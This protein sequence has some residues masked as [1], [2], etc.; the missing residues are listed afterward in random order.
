MA[1]RAL[2]FLM[3]LS[4][5]A[6]ISPAPTNP[7]CQDV[8]GLNQRTSSAWSDLGKCNKFE[9][10][11]QWMDGNCACNMRA[12]FANCYGEVSIATSLRSR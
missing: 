8:N 3:L 9:K 5:L 1:T 2:L 6:A 12:V 7:G 11:E 10:V 4:L